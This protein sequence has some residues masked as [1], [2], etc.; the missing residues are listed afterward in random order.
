MSKPSYA[1]RGGGVFEQCVDLEA[2]Y[3]GN[4]NPVDDAVAFPSVNDQTAF[5]STIAV[6]G[7]NAK[8]QTSGDVGANA[9][10]VRTNGFSR[11]VGTVYSDHAGTVY[12]DWSSDGVN[13]DYSDSQAVSAATGTKFSFEVVA[14]YA[15]LRYVN[16]GTAQTVFRLYAWLRRMGAA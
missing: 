15:S 11:I 3:A 12:I 6:L 10:F 7:S 8:Y 4:A 1:S 13:V 16:G 5:D 9:E 2:P 14:P